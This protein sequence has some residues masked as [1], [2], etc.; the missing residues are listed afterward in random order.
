[1]ARDDRGTPDGSMGVDVADYDNSCRPAIWCV[2]YQGENHCLYGNECRLPGED[3]KFPGG[4]EF[5]RFATMAS[6]ISAIGQQY[7]G[8]GTQFLDLDHDGWLDLFVANGHAIR[9]PTK[10]ST[11]AQRPVL[12]YNTGRT[13]PVKF[14]N[15]TDKGGDYFQTNH[16]SRGVAFGDL[17]NDGRID[18]VVNNLNEPVVVLQ[19]VTKTSPN[20]WLGVEL[21][22]KDHRDV[23]GAKV[24]LDVDGK[25]QTRYAK[26]GGSYASA[27]DTRH[28][29]GLGP[30]DHVTGLTVIWKA[31]QEQ[32]WEGLD[33]DRYWRLVEG[34]QDARA[35]KK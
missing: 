22:S 11:R 3:P 35:P 26:G 12:M 23:V 15:I 21:V 7:V 24:I 4:R 14:A 25:R 28:V 2:N 9:F 31:G 33:V 34:E 13:G 32:H 20:H 17:D 8:W 16:C 18:M 30:A 27:N 29:F 1:V 5:F 19:N 10:G 6:G